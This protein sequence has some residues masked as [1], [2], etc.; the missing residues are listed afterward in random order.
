MEQPKISIVIPAYNAA[1][2]LRESLGSVLAQ[3]YQNLE[4]ILVNDGSEDDTLTIARELAGKDSRIV[5]LDKENEGVSVGRN[6]G[7]DAARGEFI[8]FVDADDYLEPDMVE[9]LYR[10][11]QAEKADVSICGASIVENGKVVKE[12]FGTGTREVLTGDETLGRLLRAEKFNT[13]LWTKLFRR[14]CIGDTYYMP[15]VAIHEDKYFI[16]RC[17]LNARKVVVEDVSKYRYIRRPN[18]AMTSP[19]DSRRF[20][21]ARVSDWILEDIRS[22]RPKLEADARYHWAD[23]FYVLL[24]RMATDPAAMQKYRSEY[25]ELC[26]RL[27]EADLQDIEQRFP[28]KKRILMT[29]MTRFPELYLWMEGLKGAGK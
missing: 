29:M 17:L 18:S 7:L 24:N 20:D 14:S 8:L 27:A 3:T 16:F 28:R 4:I 26:S 23:N 6:A 25:K 15:G 1:N 12:L 21:I 22:E 10:N 5:V 11:I 2:Y 13:G 19:F 9:L